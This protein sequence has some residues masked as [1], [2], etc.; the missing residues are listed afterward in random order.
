MEL[1]D[2]VEGLNRYVEGERNN[3]HIESCGHFVLQREIELHPTFKAYKSYK[4]TVWWVIPRHKE[5]AITICNL[6]KV[7]TE[8]QEANLWK[9]IGIQLII[10]V[11]EL[12]SSSDFSKYINSNEYSNK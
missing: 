4:A 7:T 10:K 8:V 9:E 2:I 6:Q 12:V 1:E 3:K 11:A 5:K